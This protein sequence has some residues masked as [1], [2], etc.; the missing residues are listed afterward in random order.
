MRSH[1]ILH[2]GWVFVLLA[3]AACAPQSVVVD[4]TAPVVA[5]P[6][7]ALFLEAEQTFQQGSQLEALGQFSRY[8]A[9]Y[10]QGR[11][12]DGALLQMAD[13]YRQQGQGEA[14]LAFYE[15]LLSEFPASNHI[16]EARLAI[17]DLLIAANRPEEALIQADRLLDQTPEIEVRHQLWRRLEEIARGKGDFG[18]AGLY[19]YML[20]STFSSPADWDFWRARLK[21]SIARMNAAD[22]EV[23]WDRVEDTEIKG[24][25]IYR[26]AVVRVADENYEQ[27]LEM[28]T[29]LLNRYPWHPEAGQA[30][31]LMETLSKQLS[32]APHTLGCLLPLSGP[33]ARYG[34]QALNGIEL[35]LSLMQQGENPIPIKLVIRDTGSEDAKT[36][37]AV[38]EL[39]EA[40]VAAIIGPIVTAAAAAQEAQRLQIPL[41]AITQK[42]DIT[43]V[44]SYIFRHFITPQNQVATLV[45]YFIN[46]IG[47]TE[48]AVMYPQEPYGV[49]FLNLFWDAVIAQGG[50]VV[51][52]ESYDAT[53]TDFAGPI[54]KLSGTAYPVPADLEAKPVVRLEENPYFQ[55]SPANDNKLES[56]LPDPVA[57]LTGLFF[58][59]PDQDR[60]RGPAIGRMRQDVT[61]EPIIDFDVLFLPDAP[62]VAGLIIPQL[63]YHDITDVYLAGTNLWHSDQLI[64]MAKNYVQN[65]VLV[66]GFFKDSKSDAVRRFVE[67]FRTTYGQDPGIIEAFAFDT[68]RLLIDLVIEPGITMR[69]ELRNA[70]LHTYY[71]E[72]ITGPTAFDESGEPI[73]QLSLLKV[74]GSRFAEIRHP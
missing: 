39:A 45:D 69:H 11:Y 46:T 63:A 48:F 40:K 71:P 30:A 33:Y 31:V 21:E 60:T 13:I 24:D 53:L 43:N 36:V 17:I 47:L 23:I 54:K 20:F 19:E 59:N 68:A 32:F 73:K 26:C 65:A 25:L 72:G 5:E 42:P 51:A 55:L 4:K 16:G 67:T 18:K 61:D 7:D 6:G 57:R 41:I 2:L 14:A 50:H 49:T 56:L 22:L 1:P 44:G 66:D 58:Q 64:E 9:Q 29:L 37:Q 70:L 8:L 28:V 38:R 74:E 34:Q 12:A 62:T 27:A 15:R 35:A 3:L 10:P 52:A